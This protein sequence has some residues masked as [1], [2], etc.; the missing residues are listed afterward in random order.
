MKR[1]RP[2]AAIPALGLVTAALITP[3]CSSEPREDVRVTLCKDIVSVQVGPSAA[4]NETETKTKGYEHAAVKVRYST[5]GRDAWAICYYEYKAVDDTA[6]MLADPLSAYATSPFEVTLDGQK[7]S[8][9]DLAEAIKKAMLKQGKEFI[10]YAKKG[11]E[12]AIQR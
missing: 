11:I 6:D 7:L 2:F 12:N 8:R 4:V 5:Q 3:G 10:D 1:L 9:A